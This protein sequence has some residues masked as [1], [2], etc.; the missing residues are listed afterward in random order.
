MERQ[1]AEYVPTY[2]TPDDVAETMDLPD[3]NDQLGT[4]TFTDT[5]HPSYRQ[6]CRMICANEDIIDRRIRRS[7]RENRVKDELVSISTYQWDENSWRT[8]YYSNGGN[9]IQLRKNIR[10][11]DPSKGDRLEVR[12]RNNAWRDAT[13]AVEN[14]QDC[15]RKDR[16]EMV[17]YWFDYPYGKLYIRTR[18][19]QQRY[20][21]IRISYRYGSDE[22]VPAAIN[23]LAC[24]LT[25]MQ[26]IT[27]QA[28]NIKV[29]LGG[30]LSNT[31]D[32]MIANWQ[33]EADT[34]YSSFQRSGSVH[35]L[36]R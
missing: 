20:N 30:D 26:I 2:C 13:D 15:D 3:P 5:T 17:T 10:P 27:M 33:N 8:A 12:F 24:L 18:V 29:G 6:V 32:V 4:F 9:F 28:F 22:P 25:A 14:D 23:R 11:W 36:Y 1:V 16:R 19:F 7:W 31:R 21:A 34:I 35:S